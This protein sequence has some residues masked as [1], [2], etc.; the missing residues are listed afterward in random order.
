MQ[1]ISTTAIMR[2]FKVSSLKNFPLKDLQRA[3]W[4][5][6]TC[7]AASALSLSTGRSTML[8]TQ[9]HKRTWD[10]PVSALL[11]SAKIYWQTNQEKTAH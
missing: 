9:A 11:L 10:Q 2:L 6:A 1:N 3:N 8:S 7:Q 4:S 5:F